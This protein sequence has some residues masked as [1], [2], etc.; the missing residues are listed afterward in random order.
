MSPRRSSRAR[1]TQSASAPMHTNSSTSS[2]SSGRA[3]RSTR[4]H[5]KASSPHASKLPRSLSLDDPDEHT[6]PPLRRTRSGHEDIKENAVSKRQEQD[7]KEVEEEDV[8]RCICGHS[9][10]QGLPNSTS[11]AL[12]Q[13]AKD[14]GD[15]SASSETVPEDAGGLFIQCD[16]CK[17]WQHNCCVGI[18]NEGMTPEEYFCELCRKDLHRLM[19]ASN[20]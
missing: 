1:T 17:V 14:N 15:V 7:D 18:L 13:A 10:Y 5:N 4:S 3:E 6:K 2:I 12:K 20:G 9:E 11:D 16:T 19:T 8:T